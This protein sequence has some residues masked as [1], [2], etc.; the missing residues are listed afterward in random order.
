MHASLHDSYFVA[1]KKGVIH[2]LTVAKGVLSFLCSSKRGVGFHRPGDVVLGTWWTTW[3]ASKIKT[4]FN[5]LRKVVKNLCRLRSTKILLNNSRITETPGIKFTGKRNKE[6]EDYDGFFPR[7]YLYP[8]CYTYSQNA[9]STVVAIATKIKF[10][11]LG[12][13]TTHY[14]HNGALH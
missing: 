14:Y 4:F 6:T 10:P 8:F 11:H 2:A 12:I 9:S 5:A 7:R 3:R 13:N 1:V